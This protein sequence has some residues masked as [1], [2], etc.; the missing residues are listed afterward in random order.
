MSAKRRVGELNRRI[1]IQKLGPVQNEYGDWVEGWTD[2]KR[3]WA[4]MEP[5]G[6]REYW[7]SEKFNA[8]ANGEIEIRY[9]SDINPGAMRILYKDR[10]IDIQYFY[11]PR[12]RRDRTRLIV[13]EQ[14]S[15]EVPLIN[16]ESNEG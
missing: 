2:W 9:Q 4:S 11:H 6:G 10:V 1:T 12:E 16:E 14:I 7:Q 8:E 3:V 13:K 15:K 5:A